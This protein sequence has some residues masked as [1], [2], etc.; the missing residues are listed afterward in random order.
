MSV[1]VDRC[2]N[3]HMLAPGT[4]MSAISVW[5]GNPAQERVA[6]HDPFP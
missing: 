3:V 1:A 2:E 4:T 5:A 6:D